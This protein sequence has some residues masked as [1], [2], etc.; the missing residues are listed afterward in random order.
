MEEVQY[1]LFNYSAL[2]DQTVSLTSYHHLSSLVYR[3]QD[4][5]T[6]H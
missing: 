6:A 5:S 2:K 3:P 1:M 4:V